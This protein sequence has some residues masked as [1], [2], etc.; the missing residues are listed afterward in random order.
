MI[1]FEALLQDLR[2]GTRTLR[3]NTAFTVMSVFVLAL[4]IGVNTAVF[5][6]VN[7]VLLKPL[8][9]RDPDRIVTLS[10]FSTSDQARTALSKQVSAREFQDWRDQS[11]SFEAMAYY[12]SRETAVIRA[13]TAEYGRVAGV[14]PEIFRV[15]ALEAFG[16]RFPTT[17]EMKPGGSGAVMISYAYWQSHFGGDPRALGQT[18]RV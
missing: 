9:Y 18:V 10:D 11:S 17:E 15:F 1:L 6:V 8:A 5:T 13:S 2:Y 12:G 16:G 14:S 7:A 3:R 4:G